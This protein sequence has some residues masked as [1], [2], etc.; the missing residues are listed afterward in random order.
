[1]LIDFE[2]VFVLSCSTSLIFSETASG[3]VSFFALKVGGSSTQSWLPT[4]R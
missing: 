2:N 4:L 1:M 3:E